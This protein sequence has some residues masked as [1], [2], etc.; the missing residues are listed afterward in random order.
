MKAS[1]CCGKH[2]FT[3]KERCFQ[4]A[5]GESGRVIARAIKGCKHLFAVI[6]QETT[7]H[8]SLQDTFSPPVTGVP[9]LKPL[10]W[11]E[12]CLD[13]VLSWRRPGALTTQKSCLLLTTVI[14]Q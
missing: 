9:C 6:M 12:D 10:G 1:L 4:G 2:D 5:Y 8:F 14:G 3:C 11:Q 7:D 13:T